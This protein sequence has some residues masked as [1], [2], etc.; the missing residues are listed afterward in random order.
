MGEG[1]ERIVVVLL[2]DDTMV[3]GATEVICAVSDVLEVPWDKGGDLPS[4]SEVGIAKKF[5]ARALPVLV[6]DLAIG[7]LGPVRLKIYPTPYGLGSYAG[8]GGSRNFHVPHMGSFYG[9]RWRCS[10]G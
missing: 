1:A 4:T 2:R 5:D 7:K 8:C 3:H 6:L 10:Y 9:M